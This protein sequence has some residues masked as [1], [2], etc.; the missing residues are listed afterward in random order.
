MSRFGALPLIFG[1]CAAFC[2]RAVPSLAEPAESAK[3]S[4]STYATPPVEPSPPA[5]EEDKKAYERIIE[6][7][8]EEEKE[9]TED[10]MEDLDDRTREEIRAELDGV[11][12][13]VRA[14]AVGILADLEAGSLTPDKIAEAYPDVIKAYHA[15]DPE[16]LN[17]LSE[18]ILRAREHLR[19]NTGRPPGSPPPPARETFPRIPFPQ[20]HLKNWG[21]QEPENPVP[22]AYQG[23]DWMD[24][25]RPGEAYPH[26][27]KAVEGG[28]RH[29]DLLYMRALAAERLGDHEAA[30]ADA[31]A[32]LSME[33]RNPQAMSLY[34]LTQGRVST[35]RLAKVP[36]ELR[37]SDE[38]LLASDI[39]SG[40]GGGGGGDGSG[41]APAMVSGAFRRSDQFTR[42][43]LTAFK[44][45]D[46][47]RAVGKAGKAIKLNPRNWQAY[48][49]RAS[50]H[51]RNKNYRSA[52]ADASKGLSVNPGS[53]PLLTA[54]AMAYNRMGR[55]KEGLLDSVA[56]VALSPGNGMGHFARA[57]SLAGLGRRRQMLE[58]LRRAAEQDPRLRQAYMD[59]KQL[60]EDQDTLL[61][62]DEAFPDASARGLASQAGGG[63]GRMALLSVSTVAG[64]LLVAGG[65]IWALGRRRPG[66]RSGERAPGGEADIWKRYELVREIAA[67]GMGVVYEALDRGL[68]RRVAI[69]RMRDEIRVDRRERERFLTEARTVA[70]LHHQNIADIHSIEEDGSDIYLVFEYVD[71]PTLFDILQE[72]GCFTL[73]QASQVFRGICR[74]LDYAHRH[75]IVHRDLKPS[76]VVVDSEG[77]VKV[78]DFGV[79][80]QAKDAAGKH[81]VTTTVIGTPPYMSPEMEQGVICKEADV[82]ALGVCLYEVLCGDLPF[83]GGAPG[84]ALLKKLS[85]QYT[86]LS[87]KVSGLPKGIDVLIDRALDPKPENR[88]R[89]PKEFSDA[90]TRLAG[91]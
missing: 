33:P 90:L 81:Q 11:R 77:T 62:F 65:A 79:A 66:R 68:K 54:R 39:R 38:T 42:D 89:T 73:R 21:K 69:K 6:E 44:V 72:K 52:A 74:A 57:Y 88:Y 83:E 45:G 4:D 14:V 18:V 26:L 5:S 32:V 50:A 91:S 43:A 13:D 71:G 23:A 15:N 84:E 30:H 47:D 59:A 24:R 12:P 58:A 56:S 41:K 10:L 7:K 86:P 19:G 53:P 51:L 67:G 76:N 37:T 60:P 35:V 61:L 8:K 49:V 27:N 87:R 46:Y 55:Y 70:K 25:G 40:G 1:L 9:N 63:V 48:N 34:K 3:S 17:Q 31:A 16:A 29:P 64:G 22:S 78:M 85:A 75:G 80:R 36:K 20:D 82:Y 28:L 2:A